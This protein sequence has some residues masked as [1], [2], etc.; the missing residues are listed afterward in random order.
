MKEVKFQKHVSVVQFVL[1]VVGVSSTRDTDYG[2]YYFS[3]PKAVYSVCRECGCLVEP[4]NS[5]ARASDLISHA[6]AVSA[7]SY[8]GSD[9]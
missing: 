4:V 1:V 5:I 6:L 2:E 7:E 9:P 8:F 3:V